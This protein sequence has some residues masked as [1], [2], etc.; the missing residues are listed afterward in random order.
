[1]RYA[2][3][4]DRLANDGARAWEVHGRA[5]RYLREGRD[6]V[7]L[8]I[9]DPDFYTPERIQEAMIARLRAGDTHYGWIDGGPELK[10]AI[11]AYHARHTGQAVGR[12]NVSMTLG[13][14]GGL[15]GAVFPGTGAIALN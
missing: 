8:S 15:Y 1:M 2:S 6:V 12:E 13:A 9:G 10:D 11:A 5:M 3:I 4:V 14:Q 7:V